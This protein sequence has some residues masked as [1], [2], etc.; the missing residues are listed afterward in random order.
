MARR[1]RGSTPNVAPV[2]GGLPDRWNRAGLATLRLALIEA[3]EPAVW[4]AGAIA[5]AP[6]AWQAAG[7]A[8]GRSW[9]LPSAAIACGGL[10]AVAAVGDPPLGLPDG[11]RRC[12]PPLWAARLAWPLAGA[13]VASL[14]AVARSGLTLAFV[15]TSGGVLAGGLLATFT[16]AVVRAAGA[17][18]TTAASCGLCVAG[19]A[20]GVGLVAGGSLVPW[21]WTAVAVLLAGAASAAAVLTLV[22][23]EPA[24]GPSGSAWPAPE[25][26]SSLGGAAM[27]TAL[28][29]MVVCYFLAPQYAAGYT[30]LAV[31]WF[32]CLA[33]PSA[34]PAGSDPCGRRLS[35]SAVG[36]PRLPG[37]LARAVTDTLSLAALLGWPAVVALLLPAPSG[38]RAV[39][40]GVTLT[41][42]A[43]AATVFITVVRFL[44]SRPSSARAVGLGLAAGSILW[45]AGRG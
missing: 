29:A 30:L 2:N 7:G 39:H 40:P 31:G 5:A 37:S 11:R 24:G 4:L 28:V 20:A 23:R 8:V 18:A 1:Q 34:T 15:T 12:W 32:V 19:V 3:R 6:G 35:R 22:R 41:C 16:M 25:P 9:M 36:R 45:A 21:P 43:V 17:E 44:G 38:S 13:T 26:A 27:L 10:A 33:I 14:T 42:L